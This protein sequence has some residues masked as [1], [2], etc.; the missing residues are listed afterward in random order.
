MLMMI[1]VFV[2]YSGFSAQHTLTPVSCLL[3]TWEDSLGKREMLWTCGDKK[4]V[5]ND[6]SQVVY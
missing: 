4:G 6:L 3:Y 1:F 5:K 2:Y